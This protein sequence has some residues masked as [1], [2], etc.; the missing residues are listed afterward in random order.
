MHPRN[1]TRFFIGAAVLVGIG[2]GLLARYSGAI[3]VVLSI[4]L[5][6][7]ATSQVDDSW[8]MSRSWQGSVAFWLTIILQ[9][10]AIGWLAS[11]VWLRF[12]VKKR[13]E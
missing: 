12:G 4:T 13:N 2:L 8:I 9:W 6:L 7:M 10:I 1:H 3:V 5:P 11:L